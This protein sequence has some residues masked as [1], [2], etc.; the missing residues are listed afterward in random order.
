[1][2]AWLRIHHLDDLKQFLAAVVV[3]VLGVLF[4][5]DALTWT[6]GP[7]LL[8]VG[9]AWGALIAAL[10]FVLWQSAHENRRRAVDQA[11]AEGTAPVQPDAESSLL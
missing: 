10:S 9:L 6:G 7:E 3:V 8:T 2:P 1:M 11:A 5:G 4:L